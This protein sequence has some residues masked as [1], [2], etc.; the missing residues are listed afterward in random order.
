M[1]VVVIVAILSVLAVLGYRKFIDAAHT[2]EAVQ[3]VGAIKAAE[4]SYRSET[5]TYLNVCN[6]LDSETYPLQTPSDKKT[7][8]GGPGINDNL[9]RILNVTVDA[10]V[11]YGYCVRA[12]GPGAVAAPGLVLPSQVAFAPSV[13]PWYI[14]QAKGDINANGVF[15]YYAT[16]SFSTE[17]TWTREGE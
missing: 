15:S 9:W 7:A 16:T 14:V 1:A 2:S 17:G 11:M 13:E 6:N 3:V 12:G 5:L 8:W 10:P 4:E